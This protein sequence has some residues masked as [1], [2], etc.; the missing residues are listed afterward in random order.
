MSVGPAKVGMHLLPHGSPML[1]ALTAIG[2]LMTLIDFTLSN[3]RRFYSSMGNPLAVK[4]LT[5][6]L[7]VSMLM[8]LMKITILSLLKISF[9]LT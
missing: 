2:A 1:N 7:L 9:K 4:G 8:V 6:Q 3:A 5:N